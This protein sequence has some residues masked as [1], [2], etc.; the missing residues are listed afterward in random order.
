MFLNNIN[1]KNFRN[2]KNIQLN[3]HK[4]INC[5]YGN[6]A[7]GKTNF[8]ESIFFLL[9]TKSFKEEAEANLISE[10]NNYLRLKGNLTSLEEAN[11]EKIKLEVFLQQLT[12]S[13]NEKMLFLNGRATS[14]KQYLQ[15][16]KCLLFCWEDIYLIEGT[17][18]M[19]RDFLDSEI[20][21]LDYNYKQSLQKYKKALESR[22]KLLKLKSKDIAL[23]KTY[24]EILAKEAEFIVE[25][26]NKFLQ[27]LQMISNKYCCNFLNKEIKFQYI[28]SCNVANYS[29]YLTIFN[30][31]RMQEQQAGFTLNGVQ[32]DDFKFMSENKN[33]KEFSSF[34]EKKLLV[35]IIKIALAE[36]IKNKTSKIP[37]LLLDDIITDFDANK[38]T[39]V[40]NNVLNKE[41][42]CFLTFIKNMRFPFSHKSFN[43]IN[44]ELLENS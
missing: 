44:G 1:L 43:I 8:L 6:N 9:R 31:F 3:F 32:R 19:R 15:N 41:Y 33:F 10:N 16:V 23:F 5:I 38:E 26:R 21:A 36:Y 30:N 35:L 13:K 39:I 34:G 28:N 20:A 12:L 40:L 2:L 22:N 11:E 37:V 7:Q 29:E 4:K 18:K 14:H 42:Q 27:D 24:E 17:P 25:S